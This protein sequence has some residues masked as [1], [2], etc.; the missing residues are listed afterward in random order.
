MTFGGL[1]PKGTG[2]CR[3]SRRP[4]LATRDEATPPALDAFYIYIYNLVIFSRCSVTSFA[5]LRVSN[6]RFAFS[7][8]VL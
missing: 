5:A 2:V 8:M 3:S 6:T 1:A 4:S 7:T